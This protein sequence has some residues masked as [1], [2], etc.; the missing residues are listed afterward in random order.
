MAYLIDSDVVIDHLAD[1]A[2]ALHLL[3]RLSPAGIAISVITYM[4]VYQGV[5]VNPDRIRAERKFDDF[6]A[7]VPIASF[8][9]QIAR[10]CARLRAE[11]QRQRKRVCPRALD[12]LTAATAL[13]H[14]L[15][16]VTRNVADYDDI[17]GLVV[18]PPS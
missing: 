14:D 13:E 12:L 1:E 6:L 8:S 10:R 2:D 5:L 18:H 11:L 3:D 7:A 9:V 4:E 17:P 15:V 16:L